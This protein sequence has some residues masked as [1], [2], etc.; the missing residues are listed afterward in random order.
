[1]DAVVSDY[2]SLTHA[3]NETSVSASVQKTK[4]A[5]VAYAF[6]VR[7]GDDALRRRLNEGAV[8]HLLSTTWR[9]TLA[10]YDQ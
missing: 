10:E 7:K 8:R 4:A 2:V 1:M 9:Q 3:N 6:M 5:P